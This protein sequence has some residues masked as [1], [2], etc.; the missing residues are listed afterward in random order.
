VNSF[1]RAFLGVTYS[2]PITGTFFSFPAA[3]GDGVETNTGGEYCTLHTAQKLPG[4]VQLSINVLCMST[5]AATTRVLKA[6]SALWGTR[7][8]SA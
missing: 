6:G 1:N 4:G 5:D 7:L 8:G 2:D 3:S